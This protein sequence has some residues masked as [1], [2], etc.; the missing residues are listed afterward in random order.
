MAAATD[1]YVVNAYLKRLG[2]E[3]EPPSAD[4]L[5]RLHRAHVERVPYETLWISAQEAWNIDPA[6]SMNR[7]VAHE[8][9]GYCF[10]LNASFH[11][12][13]CAL[14]YD[15]RLHVGN[16]HGPDGPTPDENGNHLALTVLNVPSDSGDSDWYV[17]TG[18][19][20]AL[21]E[22]LPLREA[23][24]IQGPMRLELHRVEANQWHLLHDPQRGS[25]AAMT[26]STDPA[27]IE[28]FSQKHRE[29][30]T[31]PESRF[32]KTV[33][34]QRRD[35]DGVDVLRGLV[36][37]RVGDTPSSVELLTASEWFTALDDVFG[38]PLH[39]LPEAAKAT[40]WASAE[41]A[42]HRWKDMQA[43]RPD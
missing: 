15:C 16:V 10:H 25:F 37:R 35:H 34:V 31:S 18:L 13:L 42:H 29:L 8:R 19:G 36:L 38:L 14:G 6:E 7:I 9:G 28:D 5:G 40:L 1:E 17:D 26:F 23:Q 3:R 24:V 33:T 11:Q 12:L 22:P 39:H 30:S 43:N 32:V 20:D 2:L 27:R 21:Y 4:A 41:S